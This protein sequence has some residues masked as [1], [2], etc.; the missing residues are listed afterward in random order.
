MLGA[1]I[2]DLRVRMYLVSYQLIANG[3]KDRLSDCDA[4]SESEPTR[5]QE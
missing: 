1:E 2:T 3:K 4:P 5:T